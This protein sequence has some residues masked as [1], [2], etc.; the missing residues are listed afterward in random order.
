MIM[1]I[2]DY[3]ISSVNAKQIKDTPNPLDARTIWEKIKNWFGF[4]QESTVIPLIKNTF[5]N[6]AISKL[7][8]ILGFCE[9]ENLTTGNEYKKNFLIEKN[10]DE[11]TCS[12]KL[13][14]SPDGERISFSYN[15][16]DIDQDLKS[17]TDIIIAL[18]ENNF[19]EFIFDAIAIWVE[20]NKNN[21]NKSDDIK[22]EVIID[23][24]NNKIKVVN[25]NKFDRDF[26]LANRLYK[27][28]NFDCKKFP[29]EFKVLIEDERKKANKEGKRLLDKIEAELFT[30]LSRI[31]LKINGVSIAGLRDKPEGLTEDLFKELEF[32]KFKNE[33]TDLDENDKELIYSLLYQKGLLEFKSF[34][35]KQDT[36]AGLINVP[37]SAETAIDIIKDNSKNTVKIKIEN[38]KSLKDKSTNNK[39][40]I[41]NLMESELPY[42]NE[43][44][45]N[46]VNLVSKELIGKPFSLEKYMNIMGVVDSH[47]SELLLVGRGITLEDKTKLVFEYDIKNKTLVLDNESEYEYAILKY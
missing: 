42:V 25:E 16:N 19:D 1:K 2:A 13:D 36:L 33:F 6:G 37:Y 47:I 9:L 39:E 14:E 22:K 5:F 46:L 44:H 28:A 3:S 10:G 17:I 8:K 23:L 4:G 12:I 29:G 32:E 41:V 38:K 21:I 11:I 30:D 18:K 40:N 24:I 45:C 31:S 26:I 15:I 20:K 43:Q 27:K 34:L 7:D 35:M